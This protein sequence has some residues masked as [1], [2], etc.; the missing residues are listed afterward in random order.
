MDIVHPYFQQIDGI[1]EAFCGCR[2]V[3]QERPSVAPYPV[4]GFQ[5]R[6]GLQF[7]ITPETAVSTLAKK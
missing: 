3:V 7:H 2:R 1:P 5:I 6:M 4:D